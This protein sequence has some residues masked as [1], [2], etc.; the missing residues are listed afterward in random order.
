MADSAFRIVSTS[1]KTKKIT[2][3]AGYVWGFSSGL[4]IA[5]AEVTV[6]GSVSTPEF[7]YAKGGVTTLSGAIQT[8][9]KTLAELNATEFGVENQ[10]VC[11]LYRVYISTAKVF[12]IMPVFHCP[13]I[14]THYGP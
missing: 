7:V 3:G 8:E 9:S 2:V 4:A 12:S 6:A 11:V 14:R 13:N 1:P 10:W 5:Q